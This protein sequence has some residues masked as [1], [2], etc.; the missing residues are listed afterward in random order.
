MKKRECEACVKS[1]GERLH[2]R[3]GRRCEHR[4]FGIEEAFPMSSHEADDGLPGGAMARNVNVCSMSTPAGK[5]GVPFI[6]LVIM[7][8]SMFELFR[9]LRMQSVGM[10][11]TLMLT[12]REA[13]CF[14]MSAGVVNRPRPAVPE[15][16]TSPN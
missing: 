9:K 7:A 3:F 6:G 16:A 11:A 4:G 12:T 15:A 14:A 8:A 1:G 13:D 2:T 10:L 5:Y